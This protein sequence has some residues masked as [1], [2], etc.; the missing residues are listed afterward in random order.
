MMSSSEKKRIFPWGHERRFNAY[1]NY[2]KG[3][4][5]G[6]VQKLS[7]NA[8]FT[9]PNRDGKKGIGGC[10]FC[11][12]DAFSPSYCL[13]EKSVSRQIAEGMAFHE[14][15]YRR[16]IAYM[17]Y[18]QSY[19]NTYA[20]IDRLEALYREALNQPEV[21]GLVIGTRPDCINTEILDLLE[22][23]SSSAYVTVEYGLESC[24]NKTLKRVNR[25]HDYETSVEA[26]IKTAERGIHTGAHFI[27][28]LPGESRDEMMQQADIISSLPLTTVK[29]HQLQ[30]F[31][32]T[33]MEKEYRDK[34]DDFNFFT[35][36]EYQEFFIKFLER[37]NP[38][39]VVERFTG[40][41]SP[42]L[43]VSP[44]WG[45]KRTD[46]LLA[47]FERRMEELDTWQGRLYGE[48]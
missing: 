31:K 38:A 44:R 26:I 10:T 20:S 28:G 30:I 9:C 29:F 33:I 11:N 6:R 39:L 40:E 15:R 2:F 14:K 17:A 46:A 35:W 43:I 22:E 8:G 21:I 19:T 41:A 32:G 42:E 24:Y 48:S 45:K 7:I 25:G 16:S 12:N 1:S 23:L 3:L 36:D 34:P 37:L 18:F 27:L 5:G 4:F 13:S 47:L